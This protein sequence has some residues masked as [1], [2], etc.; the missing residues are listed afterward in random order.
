LVSFGLVFAILLAGLIL[1]PYYLEYVKPWRQPVLQVNA[2]VFDMRYFVKMLR[3]YSTG[4]N[5]DVSTPMQALT[6]IQ[7]AE[8]IRQEAKRRGLEADAG[9]V[10]RRLR[11]QIAPSA[12]TQEDFEERYRT[13]RERTGL[14]DD[15]YRG[16]VEASLLGEALRA[17]LGTAVP[18]TVPQVRVSAIRV[19]TAE[20]AEDIRSRI[21]RG[22]DFARIASATSL[23]SDSKGKGGDLGWWPRGVHQ[24]VAEVHLRARGILTRT[25]DDASTA[26][27]Q[28]AGGRMFAEVAR[29]WSRHTPSR[30]KGGDLGWVAP[31]DMDARFDAAVFALEPG[32]LSETIAAPEGFWVVEV[33]EQGTS[34]NLI[35]AVAFGLPV[36]ELSPPLRTPQGY[37]LI[38]VAEP[39]ADRPLTGGQREALVD[40]AMAKWLEQTARRGA[41]E[42]WIKWHWDSERYAW[43]AE[44]LR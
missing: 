16:L 24:T 15:E 37:Y 23:D 5:L 32:T 1:I 17:E 35:D 20:E 14:A 4:Q 29:E 22:E 6:N 7:N 3:L 13:V 39:P 34:G 25:E 18:P 26:R 41:D 36:G 33:L 9:E 40:R 19:A 44:H 27:S 28:I 43:A 31:G 10:T 11:S 12:A 38:R 8:L 21:R 42:G 30:V 2:S